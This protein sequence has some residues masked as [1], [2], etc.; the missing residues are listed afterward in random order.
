[1]E[2]M[3]PHPSPDCRWSFP[4]ELSRREE[5]VCKR[6]KRT[7][8]LFA[9]LRRH[10]HE[11]FDEA[12]QRELAQMYSDAPRG[13][14][15]LPPAL[16]AMVT[17]LQAYEQ[18]SDAAAVEEAVFDLRWQMVLDCMGAEEPAF[19]QGVLVDFR[20]RLTAHDMD[21]RLL[22]RTVELAQKTGDFGTKQLKVALD[23]APL[24]GAG[25]VEDTFNLIGHA[26]AVVTECAAKVLDLPVE[27]V[28]KEAK[29]VLVGGSS[30]KARLDID[31]DDPS[32]QA[33]A[34][35]RLLSEVQRLRDFIAHRLP[36][37]A[38]QPP[39]K[40]ALDL[41]EQVIGQD[42]EPDPKGGM[43]IRRGTAKD[44]R[45][46]VSDPDMRHGRKSRSRVI[47]GFKRHVAQ[48]LDQPFILAV[49]VRPANEPE[50]RAADLMR[51]EIEAFG[52]V[53]ELHVDRGYLASEWTKDLHD[54]GKRILSKPWASRNG[55]RFAKTEF[56]IDLKAQTVRCPTGAEASIRCGKAEFS[57]ACCDACFQRERCTSARQGRGRSIAIHPQEALLI[58]LRELKATT[59]GRAELRQRT[60]IEHTLAHVCRRQGPKARYKG[61]RMNVLDLRRIASVEN[62]HVLDRMQ[63]AA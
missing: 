11:L 3:H 6:L 37:A 23:S 61:E 44:R 52:E 14:Q 47:N 62:L 48:S 51:D 20:R 39:I 10:R 4:I 42:L 40:Q 29:L 33:E 49:A 1:M 26:M 19:S 2:Q 32:Q 17:L 24:W 46:S 34:L 54:I 5:L 25:R 43:R 55:E 63:Q 57:A 13:M 27:R 45:I 16:L 30:L 21:K 36:D 38:N 35:E 53:A 15:P 58:N 56:R 18:K 50:H 41:L 31:W 28:I 12:F 59:A 9:F 22:Q 8:R 60:A 7:G